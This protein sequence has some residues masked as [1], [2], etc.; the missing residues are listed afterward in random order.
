MQARHQ[1]R[2]Q[3]FAEQVKTTKAYVIPFIAATGALDE[4]TSVLEIGCGEGGN[5]QPFLELPCSEVVGVDLSEEKIAAAKAFFAEHPRAHNIRFVAEDIY[6]WPTDK[7]YDIIFLR[8]VLEHIHNQE[9]FMHF[10]KS[11]LKPNGRLFFAFPPWYNPFGGHQQ[12]CRSRL[13]SKLPYFHILPKWCYKN[14]LRLFGENTA[15]I[16]TLMEIKDTGI[17]I[18]RYRKIVKKEAYTVHK[19]TLYFINPN[20]ETKFGLK[21]R[22]VWRWAAHIP[23]LRNFWTTTLYSVLGR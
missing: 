11:L 19:E 5:L 16:D 9:R 12:I 1:N 3:Y 10:V 22:I 14:I 8:D 6:S 18:E 23:F 15:T 2:K 20:Y 17:S 21:P 13:L 7:Q 4:H